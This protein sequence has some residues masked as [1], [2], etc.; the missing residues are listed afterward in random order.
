MLGLS[1]ATY[2]ADTFGGKMQTSISIEVAIGVSDVVL[3]H[4]L[5]SVTA[6][7]NQNI[8]VGEN[9]I[10]LSIQPETV[11]VATG[12]NIT[13]AA[14]V[15]TVTNPTAAASTTG[16]I[17]IPIARH[18]L[19]LVNPA[20]NLTTVAN[21]DV[22]ID[23][24][25][26]TLESNLITVTAIRNIDISVGKELVSL[27]AAE[28]D[29]FAQRN[30]E[31]TPSYAELLL[32]AN[33][34]EV[35]IHKRIQVDEHT[36]LLIT[37]EITFELGVGIDVGENSIILSSLPLLRAGSLWDKV[38]LASYDEDWTKVERKE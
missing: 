21:I 14:Q 30:I 36:I 28:I 4:D 6:I 34:T 26:V 10:F 12:I 32:T 27:S 11:F 19:S 13:P 24:N 20:T 31:V 2:G 17:N 8:L 35:Q 15:I 23:E 9:T 5:I 16:T 33:S 1:Q 25:E 38:D 3:S 18:I 29:V 37:N 22:N 7:K